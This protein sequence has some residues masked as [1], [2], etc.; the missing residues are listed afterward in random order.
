MLENLHLLRQPV[1]AS[2]QF[3]SFSASDASIGARVADQ[4]RIGHPGEPLA[5]DVGQ[6]VM[7]HLLLETCAFPGVRPEQ[8]VDHARQSVFAMRDHLLAPRM[9]SSPVTAR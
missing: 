8:H 6:Q 2:V 5:P 4:E 3:S 1:S 9:R 7:R